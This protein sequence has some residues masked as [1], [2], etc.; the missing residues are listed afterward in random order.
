VT[1]LARCKCEVI[2]VK[3]QGFVGYYYGMKVSCEEADARLGESWQ[4][5]AEVNR[6]S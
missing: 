3:K 4:H 2:S 1:W 6:G 5:P